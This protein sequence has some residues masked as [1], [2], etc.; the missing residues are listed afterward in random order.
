[1]LLMQEQNKSHFVDVE[2]LER[3]QPAVDPHPPPLRMVPFSGNPVHVFHTIWPSYLL[4][5]KQPFMV[6][7]CTIIKNLQHNF[8][9]MSGGSKAVWIFF[10]KFIQFG[11]P[12]R[13]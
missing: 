13:P 9:K 12:T 11:G 5:Y 2:F 3:F 1:M 10:R 4:A 7:L 6:P 8:P